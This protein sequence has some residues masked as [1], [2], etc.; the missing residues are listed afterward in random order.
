MRPFLLRAA[1]FLALAFAAPALAGSEPVALP[2]A[3]FARASLTVVGPSGEK[4]YSPAELEAL[5]TYRMR[6]VTPWLPEATDHDG[7]RLADVLAAHG[8]ADA[9]AVRIIAENDYAVVVPRAAWTGNDALIA[10]RVAGKPH[11]RRNKGPL[12]IVFPMSD[13]PELGQNEHWALWVWMA[14]RIEPAT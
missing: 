6:T 4:T 3:D 10:T 8:L 9:E 14:A 13:R 11:T 1:A 12:Q 5:G 2:P 7:V